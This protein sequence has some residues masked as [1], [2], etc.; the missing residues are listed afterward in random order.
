MVVGMGMSDPSPVYGGL[1]QSSEFGPVLFCIYVMPLEDII[2]CHGL[3]CMTYA[4]DILLHITC[5]GNQVPTGT[6]EECVSAIHHWMMT[7]ML[8][9]IDSKIEVIHFLAK[10][11][12]QVPVPPCDLCVGGISISPCDA[13]FSLWVMM[14]W[15][16]TM[17]THV[18][19]LCKSALFTVWKICKI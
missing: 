18:S 11:C 13:V 6:I 1:P 5:D 4:A 7:N 17:S 16:G 15:A 19:K 10:F 8:D 12:G 3:Q 14:D 9:L 2:L